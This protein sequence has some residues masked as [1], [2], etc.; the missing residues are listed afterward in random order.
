MTMQPVQII[1][2]IPFFLDIESLRVGLHIK[3]DTDLNQRL[4]ELAQ[5]AQAVARPK[6]AYRQVDILTTTKDELAIEGVT[7]KSRLL[8]DNLAHAA[9]RYAFIATC[10][11]EIEAWAATFT[12]LLE[13][14]WVDVF[15]QLALGAAVQSL[16]QRLSLSCSN[17]SL[18]CM[19]PGSLP[20]WPLTEQ[21]PLFM[22][23]AD[24]L[25]SI[26][27]ALNPSC[28]IT[29]LKSISGIY[30]DSAEQFCNCQLCPRESCP[31]RRAPYVNP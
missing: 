7:F 16:E 11:A 29:P 22:L 31:G 24:A 17:Q 15:M 27:V 5:A 2:T 1:D 21:R 9:A 8:H 6:A 13:R 20:D 28:L 12:D 26:G 14:F 19:N 3:P 18:S 10:G 4:I 25:D 23:L 30:F